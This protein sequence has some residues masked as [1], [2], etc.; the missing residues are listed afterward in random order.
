[1]NSFH[2]TFYHLGTG[3]LGRLETQDFGVIFAASELAAK[4]AV[5]DRE[6]RMVGPDLQG[7][8][9]SRLTA[10]PTTGSGNE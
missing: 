3:I 7:F 4:Q 8:V 5:I 2:V 10:T 9:M 1:M 6:F